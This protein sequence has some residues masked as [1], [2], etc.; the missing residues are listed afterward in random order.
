MKVCQGVTLDVLG[1]DGISVAP[2]GASD[3]AQRQSRRQLAGLLGDPDVARAWTS[4]GEY[5]ERLDMG[6]A[7][8]TAYLA[9]HRAARACVMG[10]EDRPPTAD[11][12]ARMVALVGQG[13]AEGALGLSTGLIYPPCCYAAKD[14]LV[15]LCKEV[16]F[17][18]GV[19]VVHIRSESD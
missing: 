1:Q 19:F 13:M 10:Q 8:S 16:A 7:I 14:E 17:R 11:E 15:A 3:E 4:V 18:R 9:P 2:V 5:L 12:L 6:T